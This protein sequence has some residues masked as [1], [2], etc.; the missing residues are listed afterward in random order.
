MHSGL[1]GGLSRLSV[2]GN[3]HEL[4]FHSVYDNLIATHEIRRAFATLPRGLQRALP[5]LT[6]VKLSGIQITA[7]D[8]QDLSTLGSLSVLHLRPGVRAG[9]RLKESEYLR[10]DCLPAGFKL[11][12]S[13]KVRRQERRG[14][15]AG[16][17]VFMCGV[18]VC[19]RQAFGF[20]TAVST[21]S[22]AS[23]LALLCAYNHQHAGGLPW[24][25]SRAGALYPLQRSSPRPN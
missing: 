12:D 4:Q 18:S 1:S 8:V 10:L 13:L 15:R 17:I 16:G 23:S 14:R 19:M 7:A 9:E 3:L 22:A 21:W 20:F 24:A 5:Q 6:T 2:L 25:G 11:P